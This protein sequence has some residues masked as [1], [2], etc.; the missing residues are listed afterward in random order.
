MRRAWAPPGERPPKGGSAL[1]EPLCFLPRT[2]HGPSALATYL[3]QSPWLRSVGGRVPR[4]VPS[5]SGRRLAPQHLGQPRATPWAPAMPAGGSAGAAPPV[6]CL[7][8]ALLPRPPPSAQPLAKETDKGQ[9]RCQV[10]RRPLHPQPHGRLAVAS[11]P[12]RVC[13]PACPPARCRARCPL[14]A[15]P[16][17]LQHINEKDSKQCGLVG[18]LDAG[19][20]VE[21]G[22]LPVRLQA[23]QPACWA[24]VHSRHAPLHNPA[25]R[26]ASRRRRLPVLLAARR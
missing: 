1:P 14:L 3:G 25:H 19:R 13:S 17:P 18:G 9:P 23:V 5:S 22:P 2:P 20:G 6:G 4:G 12:V 8:P 24:A 26:L 15:C 7:T 11:A 16:P 10:C 21:C